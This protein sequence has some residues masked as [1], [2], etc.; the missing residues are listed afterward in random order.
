M[1]YDAQ[2]CRERLQSIVPMVLLDGAQQVSEKVYVGCKYVTQNELF[3]IGH[4]PEHPIMPGV[5]QIEAMKQLAQLFLNDRFGGKMQLIKCNRVKFRNPVTPGCRMKITLEVLEETPEQIVAAAKAEI[6]AGVASEA[7][8][9]FGLLPAAEPVS[10]VFAQF[11]EFDAKPDT[12]AMDFKATMG[13]MPHRFPFLLVD[14]ISKIEGEELISIKNVSINEPIFAQMADPVMPMSLLC[15]IGAQAGCACVL[16]RPENA[17][18]LGYFM[19]IDEA[20]ML[21]P[22]RPGDQLVVHLTVPSGKSRFGKGGGYME[23]NGRRVF[24]VTL[25][26][27]LVDR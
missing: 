25:T 7:K 8:L 22:V 10:G 3:F 1:F 13:L 27:A 6:P 21:Y 14:Y 4:F 9:T 12:V 5:L 11:N 2:S 23:V 18:K 17:G 20:E 19:A 15:E 16:S 26:F 24:A